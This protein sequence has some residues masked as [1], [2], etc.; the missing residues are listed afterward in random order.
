[1]QII[2]RHKIYEDFFDDISQEDIRQEVRIEQTSATN[3]LNVIV[4]RIPKNG[5]QRSDA[6]SM[7]RAM[8]RFKE[9]VCKAIETIPQIEIPSGV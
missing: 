1:M 9:L 8:K 2:S 7:K 5:I 6:K 3:T 4:N